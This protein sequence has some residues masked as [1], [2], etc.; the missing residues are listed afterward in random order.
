MEGDCVLTVIRWNGTRPNVLFLDSVLPVALDAS[1]HCFWFSDP[2]EQFSVS[3]DGMV[4][5]PTPCVA[6]MS[7]FY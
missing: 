7:A 4:L 2:V 3:S 6:V 5:R 1:W